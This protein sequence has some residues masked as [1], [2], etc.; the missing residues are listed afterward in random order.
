MRLLKDAL[1]SLFSHK[2]RAL[3]VALSLFVFNLSFNLSAAQYR[4]TGATDST[5]EELTNWEFYDD[6]LADPD[7]VTATALPG[8][9]DDVSLVGASAGTVVSISSVQS[10]NSISVSGTYVR[11]CFFVCFSEL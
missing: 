1:K 11:S 2:K 5:W 7:W 4:W 3:F 10:V 6:S 9:S 8:A